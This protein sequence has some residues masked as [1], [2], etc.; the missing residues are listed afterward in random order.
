VFSAVDVSANDLFTINRSFD[1]GTSTVEIALFDDDDFL[2]GGDDA[3]QTFTFSG[4]GTVDQL[5]DNGTS[6]YLLRGA[7]L[8]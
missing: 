1:L 5:F 6:S 7:I 8:A 2:A 4:P 3:I